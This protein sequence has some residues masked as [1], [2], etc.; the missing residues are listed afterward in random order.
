MSYIYV[1]TRITKNADPGVFEIPNLGVHTSYKRAQKHYDSV[2]ADRKTRT[3]GHS[4]LSRECPLVTSKMTL[5]REDCF[6]LLG[7]TL[8]LERWSV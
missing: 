4:T 1:V 7:E 3:S 8:R 5:M 2:V 6:Y